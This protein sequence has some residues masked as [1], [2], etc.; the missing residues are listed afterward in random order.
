MGGV[1]IIDVLEESIEYFLL[2]QVGMEVVH[3]GRS[4][5]LQFGQ[6]VMEVIFKSKLFEDS[7]FPSQLGPTLILSGHLRLGE[8]G[9][10]EKKAF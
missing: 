8:Y 6:V 9:S 7:S 2:P 5:H 3:E 10:A 4:S 1:R